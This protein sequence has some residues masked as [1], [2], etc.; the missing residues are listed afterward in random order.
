MPV[1][2]RDYYAILEIP[3]TAGAEE[4]KKAYRKAAMKYHPDR[5]PDNKEAEE[6][7]KE[8]S[9]AYEV[10]GDPDKRQRYD[11]YGHE[12]VSSA[13][14]SEGFSWQDFHHFDDI[15][16]LFGNLED[17]FGLGGIFGGQRRRATRG[18]D[19]QYD[20]ELSLKEA[21]TGTEKKIDI[22]RNE[23]CDKCKGSG[24]KSGTSRQTCASCHGTGQQRFQQ[25]F[26]T[27][28]QTCSQ[29]RGQGTIVRSPCDL[30]K[31]SGLVQ[32]RRSISVKI[33]PGVDTGSRLKIRSEGES[34]INGLPPGDLFVMIHI[35]P[36]PLFQRQES[37]LVCDI[38]ISITQA[39]LG[40]ELNIPTLEEKVKLKLPPGTQSH[41][42]FRLRGK[43]M[44]D[45]HG[46]GHGNLHVR[47]IV[48]IP[49]KLNSQQKDLLVEFAKASGE[50]ANPSGTKSFFEKIRDAFTNS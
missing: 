35:K 24:A 18:R 32:K 3:K 20:L 7:F 40:G 41:K 43:G 11:R 37:E 17:I 42:I 48:Q 50:D 21:F 39:T 4:I 49:E 2:K 15:S 38:P 25:G 30:C 28:A 1:T 12:G 23:S 16:D 47:V 46:H 27:Y 34:G 14:G 9:E 33:P 22:P 45:L 5:N 29:C 6:K 26:F 19:L 44:P 13:F 31:G 36:H 8:A 10:L